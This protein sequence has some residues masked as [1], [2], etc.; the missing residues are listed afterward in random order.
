MLRQRGVLQEGGNA[1]SRGAGSTSGK[2]HQVRHTC[3]ST[4]SAS[5]VHI[6][7]HR[8]VENNE[9]SQILASDEL[10][11]DASHSNSEVDQKIIELPVIDIPAVPVITRTGSQIMRRNSARFDGLASDSL[12]RNSGS[13]LRNSGSVQVFFFAA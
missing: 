5:D 6:F 10:A 13:V 4:S 1:R 3:L 7:W 12:R 2:C 11:N 9:R 8:D